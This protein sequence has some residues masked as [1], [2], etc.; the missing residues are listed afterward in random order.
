[1]EHNDEFLRVL[2]HDLHKVRV[3][4]ALPHVE[5]MPNNQAREMDALAAWLGRNFLREPFEKSLYRKSLIFP[6]RN[7]QNPRTLEN[8]HKVEVVDLFNE[9]NA[10][11]LHDAILQSKLVNLYCEA[12]DYPFSSL[13]YHILLTCALYYNFKQGSKL[14]NIYLC[15]NLTVENPFQIIYH[16]RERIWALLPDR[17]KDGLS[18]L[19]PKFHQSWDYRKKISLGGDHRILAGVFSFI[20]SWTTALACIED[21]QDFLKNNNASETPAQP[22]QLALSRFIKKP[23]SE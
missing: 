10:V 11:K 23:V 22:A 15:E 4:E 21:F 8:Q 6:L 9:E 12:R 1:M 18:R 16:D 19:W 5:A 17:K 7:F 3:P 13:K 20:S 2:K 14:K